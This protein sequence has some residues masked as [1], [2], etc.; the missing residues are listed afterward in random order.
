MI[1]VINEKNHVTTRLLFKSTT[2]PYYCPDTNICPISLM[3]CISDLFDYY[4]AV[5]MAWQDPMTELNLRISVIK[6]L[7]G[8][9]KIAVGN[10]E[11][12]TTLEMKEKVVNRGFGL[13][14]IKIGKWRADATI[15]CT[16]IIREIVHQFLFLNA[17]W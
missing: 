17:L 15:L 6:S 3:I 2:C 8:E 12:K 5:E 7:S 11:V 9:A 14:K 4:K 16:W 1:N 13:K 10:P